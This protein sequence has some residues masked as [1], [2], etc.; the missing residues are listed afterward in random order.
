VINFVAI[1]THYRD[2]PGGI[3]LIAVD[4]DHQSAGVATP[5]T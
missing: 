1:R 5:L 4:L 2:D 3:S